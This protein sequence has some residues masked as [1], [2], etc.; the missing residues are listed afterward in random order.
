MS[1]LLILKLVEINQNKKSMWIFKNVFFSTS[2]FLTFRILVEWSI[3]LLIIGDW[4][5]FNC[6]LFSWLV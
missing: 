1:H 2:Q 3:E 6:E 5:I 4:I